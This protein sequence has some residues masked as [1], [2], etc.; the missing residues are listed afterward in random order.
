MMAAPPHGQGR[1]WEGVGMAAIIRHFSHARRAPRRFSMC[2]MPS[3][4]RQLPHLQTFFAEN[5]FNP[6]ENTPEK[7]GVR[8]HLFLPD[9]ASAVIVALT[10]ANSRQFDVRQQKNVL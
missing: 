5:K 4:C 7:F 9:T 6:S 2:K 3:R 8:A 10:V 1:G